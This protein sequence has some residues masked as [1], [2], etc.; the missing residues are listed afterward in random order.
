[1]TASELPLRIDE[2]VRQLA[3]PEL[4]PDGSV[5]LGEGDCLVMCAGFEAR[6]LAVLKEAAG[7]RSERFSVIS[8]DYLPNYSENQRENVAKLCQGG[9]LHIT[10]LVYD[11]QNP[12]GMGRTILEAAKNCRRLF[13]DISGMS[14]LL[15]IQVL[16]ALAQE[17]ECLRAAFLFYTEAETYPPTHS[18]F[19]ADC[20]RSQ[21][22]GRAVDSYISSGVHEVAIT[23]ELSSVAMHGQP[24]RL[25]AFPSFNREQ[26]VVLLQEVQPA[27]V[28]LVEGLPPREDNVWRVTAIRQLN[29]ACTRSLAHVETIEASTLDYR[30]TLNYLLKIYDQHGAS[31]KI[32]IAPTGSKMQSVAVGLFRAFMRD[33]Q[34]V[35]PTPQTFSSPGRHTE[36]VRRIYRLSLAQFSSVNS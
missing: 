22:L 8:I 11:R 7:S 14:R 19:E 1:M 12:A 20:E 24:I 32:V 27:F 3:L 35:Y 18:E 29:D 16:V 13:V 36:G 30:D 4:I 23:P 33:I 15:I 34:I 5:Q 10:E 31:D 25:V 9:N 26:L 2:R 6:A 17:C 28:N 21:Q